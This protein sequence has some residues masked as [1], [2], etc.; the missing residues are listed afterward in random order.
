[1]T[2]LLGLTGILFLVLAGLLGP[3]MTSLID[4]L[5]MSAPVASLLFVWIGHHGIAPLVAG[6]AV[7]LVGIVSFRL[8]ARRAVWDWTVSVVPLLGPIWRWSAVAE[9]ARLMSSLVGRGVPL[10]E[11]LRLTSAGVSNA[12][13]ADVCREL[14]AGVEQGRELASLVIVSPWLP[15]SL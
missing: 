15:A 2:L 9:M 7:V 6:L 4:D 11:A 12:H 8:F 10:P 5:E 1:P 3:M 14:A 13:L